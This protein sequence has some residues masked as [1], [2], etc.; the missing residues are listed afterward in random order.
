MREYLID[1]LMS[2]ERLVPPPPK[3]HHVLLHSRYGS[4]SSGWEDKLAVQ[5][6]VNGVFHAFFLEEKDFESKPFMLAIM[7]ENLVKQTP[8]S[9][10]Q[11]SH[12][13]GTFTK[14][15]DEIIGG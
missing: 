9:G 3:C 6:N 7:I 11:I 13:A 10:T 2:L 4:E 8:P 1:F 15:G 5:V 12:E 14:T